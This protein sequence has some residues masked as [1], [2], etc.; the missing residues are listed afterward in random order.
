M[1]AM[2]GVSQE[3]QMKR[4]FCLSVRCRQGRDVMFN[5]RMPNTMKSLYL[6]YETCA[7]EYYQ[8]ITANLE[9]YTKKEDFLQELKFFGESLTKLG[10]ETARMII[11]REG[12]DDCLKIFSPTEKLRRKF[13][14]SRDHLG[15]TSTELSSFL[16]SAVEYCADGSLSSHQ[17]INSLRCFG[18]QHYTDLKV[19]REKLHGKFKSPQNLVHSKETIP[20]EAIAKESTAVKKEESSLTPVIEEWCSTQKRSADLVKVEEHYEAAP[21]PHRRLRSST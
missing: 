18:M 9:K 21:P 12:I 4:S 3:P 16:D 8:K 20:H 6:G 1:L 5:L 14:R 11:F 2:M 13:K 15:H 7:H 17:V 19:K 10:M